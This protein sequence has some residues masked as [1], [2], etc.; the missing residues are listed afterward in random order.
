MI[1]PSTLLYHTL[2]CTHL[3]ILASTRS[4][5]RSALPSPLIAIWHYH[6]LSTAAHDVLPGL[7]QIEDLQECHESHAYS[8]FWGKCNQQKWDLD[9]CLRKEKSINRYEWL[10][11]RLDQP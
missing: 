6:V 2:L 5:E 7:Q 1:G 3:F 4:A 11:Q 9:A 10:M 8:K